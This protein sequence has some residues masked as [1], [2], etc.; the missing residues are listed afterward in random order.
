MAFVK[1]ASAL[2]MSPSISQR[3]W[4][5]V[6]T[7]S[8]K[9]GGNLVNQAEQIFGE[10]FDPSRY[11]LSHCT[12]VASVDVEDVPNVKLGS[13]QDG[14]KTI[15]RKYGNYHITPQTSK[16]VNNNGDSWSREV[17]MKSY[18]TFIGSHN[19]Q[20]H[21]QIED[22]SKGRIIDAVARDIG[23]SIYID[24]L[25]A[26]DR[27]HTQLVQDIESGKMATLSMGCTVEATICSQCGNVAVDE[28]EM[29]DHIKYAKLN[30]FM[31]NNGAQRVVAELCGHPDMGDTGGVHF[32]E[33][34]WVAVPAFTGAVMRNILTPEMVSAET[35]KKATEILSVPP[36]EWVTPEGNQ[37][38]ARDLYAGMFDDDDEDDGGG[39]DASPI[40]ELEDEMVQVVKKRVLDRLKTEMNPP[41]EESEDV[42]KTEDATTYQNDTIVKEAMR[43]GAVL[44]LVK[45]SSTSVELIDGI[46]RLDRANGEPFS[47][48]LYRTALRVG[49]SANHRTLKGYLTQCH[50]TLKRKFTSKEA[51]QM[52]RLAQLIAL[53]EKQSDIQS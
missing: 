12:I 37:K 1:Y 14:G 27:K 5:K 11:L 35:K 48:D 36:S 23:E 43:K 7:A 29:C 52:V 44:G 19:F 46:A 10:K 45:I 24:I 50:R 31:D 51:K 8:M 30:K 38:V 3:G 9:S 33:A 39:E 15:N 20:E 40:Q 13:V 28:T 17:L 42:P 4:K 21:V 26:T 25:V 49:S 6:R 32:I 41:K 47:K 16:Y 22:L 18:K 34:S 53:W 2:L